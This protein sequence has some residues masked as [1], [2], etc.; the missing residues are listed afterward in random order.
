MRP[1]AKRVVGLTALDIESKQSRC[2]GSEICDS[3]VYVKEMCLGVNRLHQ[4]TC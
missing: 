4:T 2:P 1:L 3:G